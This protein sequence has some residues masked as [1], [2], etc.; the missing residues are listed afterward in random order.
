[1]ARTIRAA[2]GAAWGRACSPVG[3]ASRT[4]LRA[5]G[6]WARRAIYGDAL[7]TAAG[8]WREAGTA[9][10][11]TSGVRSGRAIRATACEDRR[12]WAVGT[13]LR[14]RRR[15]TGIPLGGRAGRATLC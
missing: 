8:A 4:A 2:L 7:R 15:G 10:A 1:M 13:V 14:A 3:R 12:R 5:T 11:A 9:R 6:S